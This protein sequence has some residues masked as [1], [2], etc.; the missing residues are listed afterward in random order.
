M[1]IL[2]SIP[3]TKNRTK[4]P[5][6]F[7]ISMQQVVSMLVSIYAMVFKATNVITWQFVPQAFYWPGSRLWSRL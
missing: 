2:Y 1:V 6:F 4:L 3:A 7:S 5:K